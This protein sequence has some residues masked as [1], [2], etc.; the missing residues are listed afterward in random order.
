MES[1]FNENSLKIRKATISDS[2]S[3]LF[4]IKQLG[5]FEKF[6]DVDMP[7]TIDLVHQNF[8]KNKYCQILLAEINEKN[9]GICTF[10]YTFTLKTARPSIMLE[11]VYVIEE[12]RRKCIGMRLFKELAKIAVT[13]NCQ[14]IEWACLPWNEPALRFYN[15]IGAKII[16]GN[17]EYSIDSEQ[18]KM[19]K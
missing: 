12:F 13:E 14:K 3:I 15:R 19:L 9:V 10:Y 6:S 4:L 1:E 5:K 8:F 2:E 11:D 17:D 16:K 18:L 7:V